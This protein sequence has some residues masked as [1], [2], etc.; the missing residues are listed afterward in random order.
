[1]PNLNIGC[2]THQIPDY[3]GVDAEPRPGV[4]VVATVPADDLPFEPGTIDHIYAGHFIE[5]LPPW[6]V[7][8]FLEQCRDLLRSGGTLTLI[9]PDARRVRLLADSQVLAGPGCARIL[10]GDAEPLM[11]HWGLWTRER[12][13]L[14]LAQVGLLVNADYAWQA[15]TRLYDRTASWQGGAQGVKP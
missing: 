13:H 15:D 12:L 11:Q 7:I 4:D 14:A 10:L 3:L 6:D 8:P 1:M 5:H 9:V 2:W